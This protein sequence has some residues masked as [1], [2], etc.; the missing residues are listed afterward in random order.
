MSDSSGTA[1]ITVA[2]A[3]DQHLVRDGI[4]S[5]LALYEDLEVV[6]TAARGSEAIAL[7]RERHPQVFLMDIRMPGM[8]GLTAAETILSE[9]LAGQVIILTTFDDEE[10]VIRA[11]RLGASGYLLK[12]LP[13]E[14]LYQAILAVR[15][16]VFWSS[17]EVMGKVGLILSPPQSSPA[18]PPPELERLSLRERQVLRL[19]GRGATNGEIARELS[20]TEGT[21]K[22]YV[23]ALLDTLGFRDRVQAALFAARHLEDDP[24]R[25]ITRRS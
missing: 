24:D 9:N 23:S 4:A 3:D 8:D 19:I 2:I 13:P 7:A 1:P 6:G 5:V 20:L 14:E 10:Y 21:V 11:I 22:N 15:R 17:R 16:G 25:T 18:A 12:D